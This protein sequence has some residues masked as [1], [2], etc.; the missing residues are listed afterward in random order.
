LTGSG[1]GILSATLG[2]SSPGTYS[3]SLTK[4]GTGTWTL[5]GANTYSGA[6]NVAAGTLYLNGANATMTLSVSG[7]ATL[8]GN[9]S[10]ASATANVA[11]GG[12]LDF[13]HNSGSTFSLAGLN[14]LGGATVNLNGAGGQYAATP[15]ISV[16]ALSTSSSPINLYVANVP[17]GSGTMDIL[18]YSGA[19]GGSGA[20]AFNLAGPMSSGRSLYAIEDTG[21]EIRLSYSVDYPFWAGMG[22]GSW[23][24]SSTGNWYAN[25]TSAST[26]F[27]AGDKMVF[28][29]RAL[30]YSGSAV[31]TVF[32]NAA[33]NPASVTFS[34]TAVNYILQGTSQITG[35]AALTVNGGGSVT[36]ANSNSYTGGT[37]LS[38]GTLAANAGAL[39]SG[40]LSIN[41][42][43]LNVNAGQSVSSTTLSG[44]L[45]NLADP[46]ALGAG[47]LTIS[48]G[49]LDNSS[50]TA[51]T[52]PANNAQNWNGNFTF[53]GSSPLNLGTGAVTIANSPTVYVSGSTLTVGGAISGAG[54]LTKNGNGTL[55]LNGSSGYTGGTTLSAG[56]LALGNSGALGAG[57]L[58]IS[59]GSLDNTSGAAMTLSGNNAQNWSGNFTFVGSSPLN[60][61]TGAVTLNA[62]PTVN[63]AGGTLTVGG[64]V[65]GGYTLLKSGSGE[66]LLAGANSFSGGIEIL[67][68]IV[69][70]ATIANSGNSSS[71]GGSNLV[72][73]ATNGTLEV[74]GGG[75]QSTNRQLWA[76]GGAL[77]VDTGSLTL[78]GQVT[79]GGG[80][81]VAGSCTVNFNG[82][83]DS[84][85]TGP[86]TVNSGAI[87][88]S[89]AAGK[90]YTGNVVLN[91]GRLNIANPNQIAPAAN[92]TVNSGGLLFDG[93]WSQQINALT[94]NGTGQGQ[95]WGTLTLSSGGTALTVQ[96]GSTLVPIGPGGT[97]V[98]SGASGGG[99]V[100]FDN[101]VAGSAT[102]NLSM[103]LGGQTRTFTINPGTTAVDMNVQGAISNGGLTKSG[104]GILCL[105]GSNTYTGATAVNG[106][107]LQIDGAGSL[108]GG[109]YSGAITNNAALV[110]STSTNQTLDGAISGGGSL[111]QASNCILTL[112]NNNVSF[113]GP[114]T[115]NAGTLQLGSGGTTGSIDQSSSLTVTGTLAF[116]RSNN[117]TFA[118][119]ITG[120]GGVNQVGTGTVTLSGT[121]SYTGPT[122]VS[123]GTLGVS[124]ALGNTA[125]SVGGGAVLTGT[126]TIAGPVTVASGAATA[127]QG[128]INLVNGTI[129]TL[130]LTNTGTALT[131]GSGTGTAVMNFEI[132][133][134]GIADL[135]SLTGGN[136]A[137][138][139]PTLLNF[140]ELSTPGLGTYNLIT[141]QSAIGTDN[142]QLGSLALAPSLTASLSASGGTEQLII[143][144]NMPPQ[145]YWQGTLG[146]TWSTAGNWSSDLP[147]LNPV[148]RL[149]GSITDLYFATTGGTAT[150]D[151]NFGVNTLT[152]A[153]TNSVTING[154]GLLTLGNTA[155]LTDDGAAAHTISAPV[156]LGTAQTWTVNGTNPLTVSGVISDAAGTTG[157]TLAGTGTLILTN[158][159]TYTGG[160]TVN[161][162]A[163]LQLGDRLGAKG[164]VASDIADNGLVTFANPTAQSY[165]GTISGT[166]AVVAAGPGTLTLTGSSSYSGGTT[167]A[168]GAALQLGDG[169]MQNGSVTGNVL[170]NGLLT[171]ANP[172]AQTFA[173]AIS[174]A[175]SLLK[176]AAGTLTLSGASSYLGGTTVGGGAL[177]YGIDNALP[178]ASNVTIV[179]GG[180]LDLSTF[181]GTV[182]TVTLTSG[183]I[184]GD[185]SGFPVPI[186]TAGN[187]SVASGTIGVTLA[188]TDG[189][190]GLTK[191]GEGVVVLSATSLYT[192][193]TDIQQGTL[194]IT[195]DAI[196]AD[197]RVAGG[198]A[199]DVQTDVAHV[200][201]VTL[202]QGTIT[203]ATGATLKGAQYDVQSGTVGVN[204][205]NLVD[206]PLV[207]SGTGS[208][209]LEG[210]NSYTGDTAVNE[211]VLSIHE[212]VNLGAG[213]LALG[214]GTLQIKTTGSVLLDNAV[215]VNDAAAGVDVPDYNGSVTL[216]GAISGSGGLT[217][218][219]EGALALTSATGTDYSGVTTVAAGTLLAQ[220]DNAL[221]PYSNL[222]IADGASVIL[223]FGGAAGTSLPGFA[224]PTPAAAM[225]AIVSAPAPAGVAAV[226]EP[227]T[228]AMLF[229]ALMSG[230][231]LWI[232]RRKK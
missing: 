151:Q 195:A 171:F 53:V 185:A 154:T 200:D 15:A 168:G 63:V 231:G 87:V 222:V 186:L 41:G 219:G 205:G 65:S 67:N 10:A 129:G 180:Q 20:G 75:A 122:N 158:A 52:L 167:V 48:S 213:T 113:T 72:L 25:S 26:T 86:L 223:D 146:T 83:A 21:S 106:G 144:L 172:N 2:D 143:V 109:N 36:I 184:T 173:G 8:G 204:L 82:G 149:P 73:V 7:G 66:L 209:V 51:M 127:N 12:I 115:V 19:I 216:H 38:S 6:T 77:V 117:F 161:S 79:A 137:V 157:L 16:T 9:G 120:T 187:I 92:V 125:V 58:N 54:A 193:L 150:I 224:A 112:S 211:G 123:G 183:A 33:V 23:D 189:T 4:S 177:Q 139:G 119:P 71:F 27:L 90:V 88:Q 197:V 225:A 155:G 17:Q 206:T 104:D 103:N 96:G 108:G 202:V 170:N 111:R 199:W 159:N 94:L 218:T 45:L 181:S 30:T 60:L 42:G 128:T 3:T 91:G 174:G 214:G 64:A 61:G 11:S 14:F 221:S 164:S 93:G 191:T 156:A 105:S 62:S 226:P 39:G 34:N 5:T 196:N 182:G 131:L 153:T 98:L 175:G 142:F 169:L 99:G 46:G 69:V 176:T 188:G 13:S 232:G 162:G 194:R 31:Q 37:T 136:L 24:F 163:A 126:G 59:A 198:A 179:T 215:T 80:L 160:T 134:S 230:F 18:H 192:G 141:Y 190:V 55:V 28:D 100:T 208:V 166:G 102:I 178:A 132:G 147:G 35:G 207:K 78:T 130:T 107:T 29:D 68:G 110:F 32:V 118:L 116:N 133:S 124:G 56:V 217:K 89:S 212:A 114:T 140:T 220:A 50:G 101:S 228:L 40:V 227:G 145:A 43:V 49:S 210:S 203:G 47:A 84:F 70:G 95:I 22:D 165:S 148:T 76:A 85:G 74:T 81:T 201:T 152:L 135:L 229:G 57:T 97:V 121:S 1:A 138:N 44:G